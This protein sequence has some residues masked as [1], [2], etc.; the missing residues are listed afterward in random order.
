MSFTLELDG[1]TALVTGGGH[2]VGRA[3]C[4][5]FG[6]AG[7]AVIVNDYVLDRAQ[8]VADE[9]AADGVD[10]EARAFDVSDFEAV[11]EAFDPSGRSVDILVNNA[12][13]AG[14]GGFSVSSGPF[15]ES[16]PSDWARYFAVNLYGVMNCTRVALPHMIARANGRVITILSEAG[17]VGESHMAPYAAAKAGAGGFMRSIAREAGRHG[18]TANCVALATV[19]TMGLGALADESPEIAA[20]VQR[21]LSRYIV[22]RLGQPDDVAG[23][24]TF[25][26]SPMASWITGQTYPVN[27]G[28]TVN[29]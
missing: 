1:Q 6:A 14:P 19:D 4:H 24:V 18:I 2:G 25:L 21:Q 11:S 17:R 12:G 28:Y 7:A 9:L 13:N 20:R 10:A 5:A 22:R 29:Q 27:G 3:I 26:A 15:A 8:T 16:D 23:L